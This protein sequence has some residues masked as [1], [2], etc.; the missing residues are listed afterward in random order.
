VQRA[1]LPNWSSELGS[2]IVI[3]REHGSHPSSPQTLA[4]GSPSCMEVS[5]RIPT[6]ILGSLAFWRDELLTPTEAA[7]WK[8]LALIPALPWYDWAIG[9]LLIAI[10]LILEGS[11]RVVRAGEALDGSSE[12]I[13]DAQQVERLADMPIQDVFF[14]IDADILE[15]GRANEV[16]QEL[17]DCLSTERIKAYGRSAYF[18]NNNCVGR[19]NL[20]AID[21][22]YWKTAQFTYEFFWRRPRT[23]RSCGTNK[24]HAGAELS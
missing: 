2:G 21:A 14:H 17:L 18:G 12:K 4:E 9:T 6:T 15:H 5:F 22:A 20:T 16:G 24:P 19:P 10:G 8:I 7:R 13:A 1:S 11:F 3:R 23:G